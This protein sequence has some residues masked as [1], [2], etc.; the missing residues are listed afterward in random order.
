M[1]LDLKILKS[2]LQ[3]Q[4]LRQ[5]NHKNLGYSALYVQLVCRYTCS[6]PHFPIHLTEKRW[7]YV[8]FT[9][10]KHFNLNEILKES[11]V[12]ILKLVGIK[13]HP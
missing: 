9:Y 13:Q 2:Y 5:Y 12:M 11:A 1:K 7:R 8:H 3:V 4:F 6:I 10:R